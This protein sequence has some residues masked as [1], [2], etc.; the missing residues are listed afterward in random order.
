MELH[1]KVN[2]ELQECLEKK[3]AKENNWKAKTEFTMKKL[4]YVLLAA[5]CFV[6]AELKADDKPQGVVTKIERTYDKEGKLRLITFS[7]EKDG[8][9]V[10]WIIIR[11]IVHL[12]KNVPSLEW[13]GGWPIWIDWDRG[14][15][16][17]HKISGWDDLPYLFRP[18]NGWEKSFVPLLVPGALWD[19]KYFIG[20]QL[21]QNAEEND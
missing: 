20:F 16:R 13:S 15:P 14:L 3:N 8:K 9:E 7:Y 2:D 17:Y 1:I 5:A 6:C 11:R 4:I 18:P 19:D 12:G 10:G 21:V